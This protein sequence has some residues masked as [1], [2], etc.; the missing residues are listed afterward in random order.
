M[1]L[2]NW[3]E[4]DKRV[5]KSVCLILKKEILTDFLV[6]GGGI[7]GLHAALYLIERGKKV[8]LLEKNIC[9]GS[10]S[11][12]SSGFLTPNSEVE[13]YQLIGN[14]SLDVGKKIW[15]IPVSGVNLII[16]T[17]KKHK[18]DCDLEKQDCFFIGISENDKKYVLSEFRARKKMKLGCKF[19]DKRDI[20]KV[21]NTGAYSCGLKFGGNYSINSYLYAQ[22]LK[23]ILIK[24]GLLIFEHSEVINVDRNM[25]YTPH[26]SVSAKKIIFC[27][28]KMKR[29]L[30]KIA[31]GIYHAQTFLTISEPLTKN[32]IKKIFPKDRMMCWDS[33]LIYSYF[34][35]TKDNRILLGGG[36]MFTTYYP[37][38]F[39]FPMIINKVIKEFKNNFPQLRNIEFICFWPGLIDITKDLMPLVDYDSENK[40]IQYVGG[41]PGLPW[42]SFLGDYA[43]KRALGE[44]VQNYERYLGSKRNFFVSNKIQLFIGKIPAF[45]LS[46]LHA[47]Y[48]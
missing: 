14:Y 28:D 5:K 41:N 35:L 27:I 3:W 42:A 30:S 10:S 16:K 38:Y 2:K 25:V 22:K 11:G 9:G 1:I 8:V 47:E 44:K 7:A 26:G 24:R 17:A 15:N 43:A 31:D 20:K 32:Q 12:R 36:S 33:K 19:Y 34:R 29:K 13:L 46:N 37:W 4:S 48:S 18:I 23:E 6:V 45:A 40:D 39:K 21:L